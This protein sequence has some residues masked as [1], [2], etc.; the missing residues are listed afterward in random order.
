MN[1]YL[2]E[3]N[4]EFLDAINEILGFLTVGEQ[5]TDELRSKI[6]EKLNRMA[7][8]TGALVDHVDLERRII[9]C[10]KC[11]R[12][13]ENKDDFEWDAPVFASDQSTKLPYCRN[14]NCADMVCSEA[15]IQSLCGQPTEEIIFTLQKTRL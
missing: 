9:I 8:F 2:E 7:G 5:I 10:P 6:V 13:S 15:V 12:I 11:G 1:D 3:N 4:E 14:P